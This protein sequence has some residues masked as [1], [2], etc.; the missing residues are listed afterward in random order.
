[1]ETLPTREPVRSAERLR[2]GHGRD[3]GARRRIPAR[4]TSRER[5]DDDNDDDRQPH[6]INDAGF[7]FRA[8]AGQGLGLHRDGDFDGDG[9]DD[10]VMEASGPR[11]T[12]ARSRPERSDERHPLG[13]RRNTISPKLIAT[14]SAP[15]LARATRTT[16]TSTT[17]S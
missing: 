7:V 6:D 13:G 11:R 9:I 3:D 8:I 4:P 16:T 1:M 14:T 2:P 12:T 17:C 5:I 15:S 10:I